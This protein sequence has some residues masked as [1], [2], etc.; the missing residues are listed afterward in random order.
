MTS[1]K[2]CNG[3]KE[4]TK[5]TFCREC[6][7]VLG[8]ATQD[9][10]EERARR[11]K[12]ANTRARLM[13]G[14]PVPKRPDVAPEGTKWCERCQEFRPNTSFKDGAYCIPCQRSY[15]AARRLMTRYGLTWDD[16]DRLFRAQGER[17][18]ICGG[19]PRRA[20]LAVDEDHK[21]G[22]IRGLLCSR[23]NH[24]LLGTAHDDPEILRRAADYLESYSPRA[25]FGRRKIVPA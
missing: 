19:R 18:A 12:L 17:C 16:Y 14:E 13:A 1:C 23:C 10:A 6:R 24:D 15:A 21:T 7:R 11:R 20:M 25:V 4:Q 22:E 9:H 3:P 8:N 2:R 5:G